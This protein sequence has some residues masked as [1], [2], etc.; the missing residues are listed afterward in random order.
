MIGQ[1]SG[2]NIDP[3]S[4]LDETVALNKHDIN[5][6][7]TTVAPHPRHNESLLCFRLTVVLVLEGNGGIPK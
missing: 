4:N 7:I 5:A 1:L 2:G 6:S 3:V